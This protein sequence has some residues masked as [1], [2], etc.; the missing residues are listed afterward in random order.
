MLAP[1][2]IFRSLPR[3]AAYARWAVRSRTGGLDDPHLQARAARPD[4]GR[5]PSFKTNLLAWSP[6]DQIPLGSRTLQVVR[7]RHDDADELP[8]LVVEDAA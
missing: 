8:V 2:E 4:A 3:F 6:G 1:G 5:A 7:I